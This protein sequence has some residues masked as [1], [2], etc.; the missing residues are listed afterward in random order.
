MSRRFGRLRERIDGSPDALLA[1]HAI[2]AMCEGEIAEKCAR[3]VAQLLDRLGDVVP[4]APVVA[5]NRDERPFDVAR[6]LLDAVVAQAV[7][8]VLRRNVLELM[9]LVEN[10]AMAGGDHFAVRVLADGGI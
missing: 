4:R 3:V 10:R 9:R 2:A 6:E 8:E 5:D 1:L 7:A